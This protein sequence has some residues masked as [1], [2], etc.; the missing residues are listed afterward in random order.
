MRSAPDMG[1]DEWRPLIA[2]KTADPP[3]ADPA[4]V[5]TYTLALTNTDDAAITVYLT[6][7]L[8]NQVSYVGPLTYDNGSGN[9]ASGVI[10][11]TG[12]VYTATPTTIRW[13]VRI[14]SDV[15]FSTIIENTALVSDI[16]GNFSTRP[17]LILVP[18]GHVY[19]PLVLRNG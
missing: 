14:A 3:M 16:Y 19:L 9:H 11:W 15:P 8:P 6:D 2:V 13:P 1:A 7:T 12:T 18:P 4:Q 17:A 5:V 10:T